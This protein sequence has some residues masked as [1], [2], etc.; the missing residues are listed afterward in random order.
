MVP[1]C[2]PR[3]RRYPEPQPEALR[4]RLAALYGCRADEV[5]AGRGSDEAIDLLVRAFC[6]PG[7]GAIVT[8]PPTFGMYAVSARL[9]GARV[10][11]AP[12]VD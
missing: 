3:V 10:V 11:E 2:A 6:V 8:T 9:H 4:E 5:I 1:A 12:L 7:Q